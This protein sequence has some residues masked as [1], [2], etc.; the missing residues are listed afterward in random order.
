MEMQEK[1]ALLFSNKD[2][3]KLIWPLIIEQLLTV[4]VGM[5]DTVM[6]AS[7]GESAVSAV[8]LVDSIMILIIQIFAAIA[9]GGAVVA[10]Q[11][12]GAKDEDRA[13]QSANQLIL[14]ISVLS[15]A[16][17]GL[18]YLLR[19]FILHQ[20]FGKITAEVMAHS[21]T[22]LDIVSLSIPFIALYN[23]GAALFRTMG[24]SRISMYTSLLMNA[25][26]ITGNAIMIY[27]LHMGVAGAAIPTL[28]SRIVAAVVMIVL[29][30]NPKQLVH[31]KRPFSLKFDATLIKRILYIGVPNG[32]ENS[33]F[34]LG[35]IL[36]L[37]LVSGF[38][39]AA[40]AANAVSNTLAT[41]MTLPGMAIG[42]AIIT[43]V[44]RCIGAGDYKQARYYT[45]KLIKITY[46][47]LLLTNALI[48]LG[49]PAVLS[50]YH[51]SDITASMTTQIIFSYAAAAIVIWAPAFSLPNT[52]RA[53]NDVKFSMVVSILSMWI[54]RIGFSFLLAKNMGLGVFGVWIS[55]YIDWLVRSI[56][57]VLRYKGVS[58][59]RYT[60]C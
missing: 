56:L 36:L 38:G 60:G 20:V 11:F 4:T 43:V 51:L 45:R 57:F 27:G 1:K 2:L 26:N 46:L 6:I 44:S 10:G 52:L 55:M 14:F 8:S 53:A 33:M 19:G 31:L 58:W 34:Q 22:Y 37:S 35:K 9:T 30:L 40:I 5:M 39:T 54:F 18:V 42:F 3:K 29:L 15:I 21:S 7:V 13:C 47:A 41:F 16:V 23:G 50:L 28:V 24:N 59:Y 32:L 17:M 48:I 12:L 49:L 25:I